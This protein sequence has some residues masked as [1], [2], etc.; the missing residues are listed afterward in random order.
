MKLTTK[1]IVDVFKKYKKEVIGIVS[2]SVLGSVMVTV[3]PY[4]Y[5]RLFGLAQ[6]PGTAVSLLLTLIALWLTL[7]VI[8]NFIQNRA[9]FRGDVLGVKVSLALEADSYAHFLTLPVPFHKKE[10]N[11]QILSRISR[12]SWRIQNMIEVFS[13]AL[14]QFIVLLFSVIVMFIIKW[15]LALIILFSFLIYSIVTMKMTKGLMK[16]RDKE[17]KEYEKQY[18]NVYDKLYN[19]FLVKNFAM[20]KSERDRFSKSLVDKLVPVSE[21][22]SKK[23]TKLSTLQGM[24]YSI[25]F[26]VILGTAIFFLQHGLISSSEFVMFF[27]YTNLAFAPFTYIERIY[28]NVKKSSTAIK[29]LV[30]LR[31][32]SPEEM[33]HGDKEIENVRGEINFK[34]VTFG[35]SDEKEILKNINL[36]IQPGET[37]ALV[38]ESGVGKTTLSELIMGY[39][40]PKKGEIMLDGVNISKLKL[41]WLR[42][43]IAIVPQDLQLF[44]DSLLKNLR[45]AKPGATVKKIIEACKAASASEFI[46]KFP[47]GYKSVIGNRGL[48]LSMG[49]RQRISIAMAFLKNPKILILDEPTSAL[50]AESEEKVQ[51]GING[52]IRGRTTI[53]IAHRFSTVKKADRI[54]VL[55]NKK[56]VEVGDHQE[57]MKKKGIYYKL[58][59][60][61]T[62]I[63]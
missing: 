32:I 12:S 6:V 48:R 3:T 33:K 63:D 55:A 53:I 26:V 34:N 17:N 35:Y 41:S 23:D 10:K 20:E 5:G 56:I 37:I 61:Q 24:I 30:R 31:N 21:R 29:R 9:S 8:S 44:N 50:D 52:L 19:I 45:Y 36:R 7:S 18:G 13:G 15:Q 62:G 42:D 38:G 58:Y 60:L 47:K 1:F 11:G 57:L 40:Q 59:N 25:S 49:Q 43:Q 28:R 51:Q 27:G 46:E 4:I 14:P 39:Y 2:I 22:A 16:V 54:I